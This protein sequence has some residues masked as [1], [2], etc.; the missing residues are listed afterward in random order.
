M[1]PCGVCALF[2][3]TGLRCPK[4]SRSGC[5]DPF[6][7]QPNH[8]HCC[9]GYGL[10]RGACHRARIRATRWQCG[11]PET[12]LLNRINLIL[13]DGQISSC[14]ARMPVQ[15]LLQKYFA[16][17]LT[18]ITS[19]SHIVLSHRGAF[20]DRHGRWERDAVDA[21]AL[22]VCVMAGRADKACEQSNGML[23]ERC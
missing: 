9:S 15:P 20:R 10:L 21:A 23:D 8:D 14:F 19:K 1:M 2:S 17:P 5:L 22:G 6:R 3:R 7:N 11:C 13:P 4:A 18:Q 16:S 12:K